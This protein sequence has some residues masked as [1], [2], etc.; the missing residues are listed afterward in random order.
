MKNKPFVPVSVIVPCFRCSDTIKRAI[1]SIWSQTHLPREVMLVDDCSGDG[2]VD[3]LKAIQDQYGHDWVRVLELEN[4]GGPGKARNHGWDKAS[5]TY[6]AFL[7]ADDT[8]HPNKIEVQYG[9]MALHDEVILTGHAFDVVTSK[10]LQNNLGIGGFYELDFLPVSKVELSLSNRFITS[11]V[12]LRRDIP[13]RFEEEKRR[14]EDFMLWLEICFSGCQCYRSGG[15]LAFLHKPAYGFGGLSANL[16]KMELG[17]LD[18]YRRIH[19][20]GG[21]GFLSLFLLVAWSLFKFVRRL[22]LTKIARIRG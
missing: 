19:N 14:S 11:T 16:W 20:R 4:N 1:E 18:A 10:E 2:T 9:W 17:E 21:F 13:F 7:D 8:W 6:I 15:K 3:T 22:V 12:M 5:L